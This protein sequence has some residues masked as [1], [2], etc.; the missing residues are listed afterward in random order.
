MKPDILSLFLKKTCV[1]FPSWQP[2]V[3]QPAT[4]SELWAR[5]HFIVIL[6]AAHR[7]RRPDHSHSIRNHSVAG[8]S[9]LAAR[10]WD[11]SVPSSP[12]QP[13][14]QPRYKSFRL[15]RKTQSRRLVITQRGE[16]E[17]IQLELG[18]ETS[19]S[20]VAQSGSQRDDR[21]QLS[22]KRKRERQSDI[23]RGFH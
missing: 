8:T 6:P 14:L 16:T 10:A 9:A 20:G 13:A 23:C 22:R 11:F 7:P 18:G 12:S 21:P 1:F 3:F 17:H 4:L 2:S 19:E 15:H 5:E